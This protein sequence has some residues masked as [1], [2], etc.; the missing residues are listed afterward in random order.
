M[1]FCNP[2][3]LLQRLISRPPPLFLQH[4][5]FPIFPKRRQS[6]IVCR[7][8]KPISLAFQSHGEKFAEDFDCIYGCHRF[9]NKLVELNA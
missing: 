2:G 6:D 5:P 9:L 3:S 7:A 8:E 1:I 4:P